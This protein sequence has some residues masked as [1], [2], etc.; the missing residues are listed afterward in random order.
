[1]QRE[2][3][4]GDGQAI[5]RRTALGGVV[6]MAA[7]T[8]LPAAAQRRTA[9]GGGSVLA[10]VG[11]YTSASKPPGHGEG[12]ALL[13]MEPRTGA[14]TPVKV[15]PSASPSWLAFDPQRRFVYSVNEVDD[16]NGGKT[17]GVTAFGIDRASGEL[18]QINAVSSE[19]AGP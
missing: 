15:F 8:A 17:G 18:T 5:A 12:I 9:V 4:P 7:A 3:I 10:Y 6:A 1:M 14:L 2:S 19:G 13:R 16:F 11:S